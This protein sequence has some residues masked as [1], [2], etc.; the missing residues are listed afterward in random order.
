MP[1][2]I[3][4]PA[5]YLAVT[6]IAGD[7]LSREQIERLCHRYYWG[8]DYYLGR[9]VLKRLVFGSL[10]RMPAE[11]TGGMLPSRPPARVAAEKP[12]RCHKVILCAAMRMQQSAGSSRVQKE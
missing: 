4:F 10:V 9:D 2:A 8:D 7:D 3:G 6:K 12:D 11:I 5:D 1:K